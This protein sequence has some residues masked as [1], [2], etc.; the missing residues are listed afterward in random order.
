MSRR[1]QLMRA[2][3]EAAQRGVLPAAGA[4]GAV[5]GL[6]RAWRQVGL[7]RG[8][9]REKGWIWTGEDGKLRFDQRQMWI[10]MDF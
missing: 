8:F 2:A 6:F 7:A 4:A 5:P 3:G 9:Q 1:Q 10:L